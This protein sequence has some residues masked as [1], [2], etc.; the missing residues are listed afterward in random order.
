M[1]DR[2]RAGDTLCGGDGP[3][4]ERA[5][6]GGGGSEKCNG[7]VT[8]TKVIISNNRE[9]PKRC[10]KRQDRISKYAITSEYLTL[11]AGIFK[12]AKHDCL[13]Y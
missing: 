12:A 7:G 6:K 9:M 5:A 3:R 1:A 10:T 11:I 2:R 13:F 8:T 4:K